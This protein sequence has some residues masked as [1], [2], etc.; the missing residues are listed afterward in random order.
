MPY[1]PDEPLIARLRWMS[2]D[3]TD[4]YGHPFFSSQWVGICKEAAD[5]IERLRAALKKI[6]DMEVV[7]MGVDC[8]REQRDVAEAVLAS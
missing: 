4:D 3:G 5:E 2:E 7:E 6:A 1:V 8:N